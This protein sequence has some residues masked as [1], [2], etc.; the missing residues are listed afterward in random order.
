MHWVDAVLLAVAIG[1]WLLA[2][3]LYI[4]L[5]LHVCPVG[6]APSLAVTPTGTATHAVLMNASGTIES[7]RRLRPGLPPAV[8][9]R[10]HGR[11]Q[12]DRYVLIGQDGERALYR[13]EA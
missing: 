8:V 11:A 4:R 13:A 12:A 7:V 10:P 1:G 9:Y 5:C 3:V 2:L 6:T